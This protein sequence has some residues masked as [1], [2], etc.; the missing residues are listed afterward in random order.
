MRIL[1]ANR[2]EIARR[3][4]RTARRLGHETVAVY[5]DPDAQMPFVAEAD[6]RYPLGPPDLAATYLSIERLMEAAHATGAEAVHPGYGFLSERPE[7]ARAVIE[8]GL[9]WIGP[10]PDAIESMGSKIRARRLATQAGIPV[11]PG[12]DA[13]QDPNDLAAA[14]IEI[15]FPVLIKASAGGGGKGIRIVHDAADFGTAL[16]EAKEEGRRS[17]GDD[18][19]IV[20]RYVTRPRHIEVQVV[21]DRH[22]TVFDLGTRECSVQRRYQKLLE[23][24]PAPNLPSATEAGVRAAAVALAQ[25]IGYDSAGTVEYV[26]DGDTGDFYFLEMNTRLQVEHPVTEEITGFDLVEFQIRAAL[27]DQLETVAF[28][29]TGHAIEVR[30][31]AE[32]PAAGFAPR[33]GTVSELAVPDDVRW[34]SGVVAG[35][36]V[37]PHYDPMIAKF[38][39]RGPDR[40]AALDRMARALDRLVI[41]GLAS[42]TGFHRWLVDHPAVRTATVTT[43]L[44]DD[45]PPPAPPGEA[46]A[47]VLAARIWLAAQPVVGDN[48]WRA[49]AGFRLTPRPG[50]RIVHLQG[51][52]V[53]DVE[54]DPAGAAPDNAAVIRERRVAVNVEGH[55]FGF[56]VL[57][58]EERWAPGGSGGHGDAEVVTAPFPGLI[59]ELHVGAGDA[60]EPGQTLVVL[61]AMK[62]LHPIHAPGRGVVT[63][64]RVD[65]GDTV[66]TNQTLIEF[67]NGEEE[68]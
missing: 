44:L 50:F 59:A 39:V 14:A 60:V 25:A 53:H 66:T 17:F 52:S 67:D 11:I 4:I 47:A 49:L 1:I 28:T 27:G 19:V 7:F 32:D 55:G 63:A 6:A 2:G 13:S 5:A 21:A 48:P 57:K 26:V 68:E 54:V 40:Q 10:N 29:P 36:E 38:I 3:I 41:G 51:V 9:V 31:N 22:G 18:R 43:R 61:E 8:A 65:I 20:E 37:S 15:G 16:A 62:M 12:F 34:E 42:N 24:A 35:N 64:V 33:T 46:T 30:I 45:T 23:E 56:T 58:R